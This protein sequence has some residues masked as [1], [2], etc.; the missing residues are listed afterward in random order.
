[1]LFGVLRFASSLTQEPQKAATE[2]SNFGTA[3]VGFVVVDAIAVDAAG[4]IGEAGQRKVVWL[5]AAWHL[6]EPMTGLPWFVAR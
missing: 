4:A 3:P 6:G 2:L 1:V 5:L